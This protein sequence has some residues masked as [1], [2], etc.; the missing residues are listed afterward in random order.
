MTQGKPRK[1]YCLRPERDYDVLL[2]IASQKHYHLWDV[3]GG[4]G[5]II[6]KEGCAGEQKGSFAVVQGGDRPVGGDRP[7]LTR[8][9]RTG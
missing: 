6:C 2:P 8:G 5:W 3:L 4:V 9:F 7:S 1:C